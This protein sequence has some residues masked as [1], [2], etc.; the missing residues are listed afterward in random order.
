[1]ELYTNLRKGE[2]GAWLSIA[3]YI[4]LSSV[5]FTVGSIGNSEALQADGLNNFTDII[6]SVAVL[7]GLRISQKPPD[8][9][10]AYGHLRAE[11]IASLIAAFIMAIIGIQ[12]VI[13]SL[14]SFADPVRE[15]P[16]LITL[17][18][19]LGSAVVMYAVYRYNISLA[20]KINSSALR[21]AAYDN[22]S[23]ALVS[24]GASIGIIG[25]IIGFP[26]LDTVTALIVGIII[27]YTAYGIFYDAAFMLSDGFNSEEAETLTSLVAHTPGVYQVPDLKGRMHGNQALIDVTVTV[28][29]YLN[30]IESHWITEEIERKITKAKPHAIVLVHIEPEYDLVDFEDR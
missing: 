13:Q 17:W 5:K 14:Q 8:D 1:M 15:S 19:G 7:I 28:D 20:T 21:A 24:I 25:A 23:D 30:V 9:Q 2:K 4:V 26:I 18:V 29:P 16:S 22:R 6:A 3:V 10:H 27:L 12:V 11:T